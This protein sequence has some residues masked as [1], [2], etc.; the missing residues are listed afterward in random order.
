MAL[1]WG[2]NF[3]D[4]QQGIACFLILQEMVK[5]NEGVKLSE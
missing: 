3:Q 1:Y 5:G 2:P 4:D